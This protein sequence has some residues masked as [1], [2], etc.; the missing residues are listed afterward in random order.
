MTSEKRSPYREIK[1]VIFDG[2]LGLLTVEELMAMDPDTWGTLRD[3]LTD[4]RRGKADE[5]VAKCLMCE[6]P[7]YI[8]AKPI[9]SV[10]LPLFSH[11]KGGDP[12]CPWYHGKNRRP[13]DVRAQQYQGQQ[14]SK[15]HRNLCELLNSLA[16]LDK[17]Y[18]RST[19][20][21]YLAPTTGDYGRY[22][23]VYVEWEGLTP[24]VL[25]LQ[26]SY[27]SETEVSGRYLHYR[28]EGANLIW[29]LAG[30][31][32]RIEDLP[33][34]FRDVIRRHRGNAFALDHAAI[35]ASLAQKTLVLSCYLQNE[36]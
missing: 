25:E 2:Q 22:P 26:L 3:R 17:R 14:E 35:Q 30:L 23:D 10:R 19:V 21:Q 28:R 18:R 29:V 8:Q 5:L 31:E 24:F 27:T 34:N 36:D 32:A 12:D 9:R 7:V 11:F 6:S 4:Q 20:G 16:S 33:Q 1:A 15:A 13:N